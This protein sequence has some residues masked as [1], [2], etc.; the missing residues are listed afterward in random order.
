M[1]KRLVI[2]LALAL[3]IFFSQTSIAESQAQDSYVT[4]WEKYNEAFLRETDFD[5]EY[6]L[7]KM[8]EL[9]KVYE[10]SNDQLSRYLDTQMYYKYAKGVLAFNEGKYEEAEE[11]MTDCALSETRTGYEPSNY[12]SFSRGMILKE[13]GDYQGSIDMLRTVNGLMDYTSRRLEAMSQCR[14]SIKETLFPQAQSAF[15]NHNYDKSIE[16]CDAIL[17]VLPNDE[18]TLDLL[19][20]AKKALNATPIPATP[21]PKVI[22]ATPAPVTPTPTQAAPS[23]PVIS[24]HRTKINKNEYWNENRAYGYFGPGNSYRQL[25]FFKYSHIDDPYVLFIEGEYTLADFKYPTRGDW[26][27]RVCAFFVEKRFREKGSD[28]LSLQAF[29]GK[30][31]QQEIPRFGPGTEYASISDDKDIT[32]DSVT[33]NA[34]TLVTIYFEASD[35]LYGEFSTG[36][37]NIRGWIP[38]AS[39]QP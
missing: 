33:L 36:I 7:Q 19:D 37:G 4:I 8:T 25:A 17:K 22:T 20:Q 39:V 24:I 23:W 18:E 28:E 30:I 15:N 11:W 1:K 34:G 27:G 9:I 2:C 12:I 21:T 3:T 6:S 16:L 32:S 31:I 35:W 10:S 26:N 13:R 5:L 14:Q 29:S 38:K